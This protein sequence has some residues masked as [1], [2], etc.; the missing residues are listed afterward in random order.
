MSCLQYA[1]VKLSE[2]IL[3]HRLKENLGRRKEKECSVED[4]PHQGPTLV[5]LD[6]LGISMCLVLL[7]G[8]YVNEDIITPISHWLVFCL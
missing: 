8:L 1:V 4:T 2:A 7:G 5:C 3:P 6:K